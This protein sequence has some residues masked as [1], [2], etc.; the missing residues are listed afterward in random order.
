[1]TKLSTSSPGGEAGRIVMH[2]ANTL[3]DHLGALA[4][5]YVELAEAQPTLN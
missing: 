5:R 1:L 3:P 2:L 4:R